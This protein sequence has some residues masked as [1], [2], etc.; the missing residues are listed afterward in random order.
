MK[1][2]KASKRPTLYYV[3]GGNGAGKSTIPVLLMDADPDVYKVKSLQYGKVIFT[4]FP[5]AKMV[6]LGN[7]DSGKTFGGCDGL[8][9]KE[10]LYALEVLKGEEWLEFDIYFEG[11]MPSDTI[12]TYFEMMKKLDNRDMVVL[13]LSTT[14]DQALER[15]QARTGKSDEEMLQLKNVE[16]KYKRIDKAKVIYRQEIAD[17]ELDIKLLELNT[18]QPIEDVFEAFITKDFDDITLGDVCHA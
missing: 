2:F 10:I 14:Y 12:A 7:Y 13:F 5:N 17:Q 11:S 3:K 15:I 8:V 6:S 1:K 9:K 16:S 18:D 4:V